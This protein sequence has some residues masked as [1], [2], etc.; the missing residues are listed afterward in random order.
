LTP[1]RFWMGAPR[2]HTEINMQ[3][4]ISSPSAFL[5][6]TGSTAVVWC[7]KHTTQ[8]NSGEGRTSGLDRTFRILCAGWKP[9]KKLSQDGLVGI[10]G[11]HN[12]QQ[13]RRIDK[14]R[15]RLLSLLLFDSLVAALD[16]LALLIKG[17]RRPFKGGNRSRRREMARWQGQ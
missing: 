2:I 14:I 4:R 7:T 3:T 15:S 12:F 10:K 13:R 9:S 17:R 1:V 16:P 11:D 8:T 5:T 6:Q